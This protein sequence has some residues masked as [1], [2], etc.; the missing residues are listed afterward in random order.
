MAKPYV[1]MASYPDVATATSVLKNLESLGNS[2]KIELIDGAVL[3]RTAEGDV[4]I[5]VKTGGEG[6]GAG[7][8]AGAIVGVLFP[9][10]LLAGAVVGGTAGGLLRKVT[11]TLSRHDV[12][13]LGEVLDLGAVCLVA[14]VHE[15]SKDVVI[16][17]L[18]NAKASIARPMEADLTE[19]ASSLGS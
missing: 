12:K 2:R 8:I 5:V 7:A 3:E 1:C 10:S 4:E 18:S 6:V 11:R 17:A 13:E 14:V 16:D 9:P 15:E 19:I